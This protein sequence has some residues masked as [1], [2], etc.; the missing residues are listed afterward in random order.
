MIKIKAKK[1][2]DFSTKELHEKGYN[3][4]QIYETFYCQLQHNNIS[5]YGE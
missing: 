5:Y 1:L 4:R 2:L 3:L